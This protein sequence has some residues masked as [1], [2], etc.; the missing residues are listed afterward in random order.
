MTHLTCE[1]PLYSYHSNLNEFTKIWNIVMK[2]YILCFI[3]T[4]ETVLWIYCNKNVILIFYFCLKPELSILCMTYI[5]KVPNFG[6]LPWAHQL[7]VSLP[8]QC[9]VLII[10]RNIYYTWLHLTQ[11][12]FCLLVH[13]QH[14]IF[15]QIN[16][17][18]VTCY[19]VLNMILELRET[20]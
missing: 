12:H 11:Y 16:I 18:T 17:L 20:W 4:F 14:T 10:W 2:I 6:R 3:L 13:D 19:S 1:W 5:P 9:E 15:L 7:I 8:R